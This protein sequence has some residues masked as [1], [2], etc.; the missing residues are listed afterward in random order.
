MRRYCHMATTVLQ[1]CM[2]K[3]R[4]ISQNLKTFDGQNIGDKLYQY[5]T[6]AAVAFDGF[7]RWYFL[8]EKTIMV[9]PRPENDIHSN[10]QIAW[11]NE[12]MRTQNIVP[13][14]I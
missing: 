5:I 11:L 1:V 10:M 9:V 12:A 4:A 3:F 14:T 7:H 2:E 6:I 13:T 8:P